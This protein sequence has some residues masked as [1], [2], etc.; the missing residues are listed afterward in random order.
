MLINYIIKTKIK[1]EFL[2]KIGI[3]TG[4]F[5]VDP[6][7]HDLF[8]AASKV[9]EVEI[10]DPI[11][12]FVEM[13]KRKA[14][15]IGSDNAGKFDALVIRGLNFNGETDFQFEVFQQLERM[16]VL[17]VNS[18]SAIQIAESKFLTSFILKEKGFRI[19]ETVI[20]Q[21]MEDAEVFLAGHNDVIAKPLYGFQ[22]YGVIR[23]KRSEKDATRRI[24]RLLGEFKCVCLQRYIP[25]PGRDIRA[26]VVGDDVVASIYR[27][28]RVGRWKTNIRF[29][30]V[31]AACTL[32]DEQRDISIRASR[33]LGLDYTG[34]DII[35][36][37]DG[38]YILEVNGAP[39]WHGIMEATGRNVAE[40]IIN[41]IIHRLER[42]AA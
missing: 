10:V 33:C 41:Y 28:A 27:K 37:P 24:Q 20:V 34:V 17:L 16:G 32:T 36:G 3:V 23:V 12:F 35:E 29:G 38:N 30:G 1:G 21:A 7:S 2:Y 14:I 25:N 11:H 22:G 39:A 15:N 31:P 26:F 8:D 19:P 18:P 4:Q 42:R 6:T 9:S 40:D 13:N 5:G